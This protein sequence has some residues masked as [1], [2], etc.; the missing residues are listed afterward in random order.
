MKLSFNQLLPLKYIA[1]GCFFPFIS[2]C[3]GD[4][5]EI[6][7]FNS[8]PEVSSESSEVGAQNLSKRFQKLCEIALEKYP[9]L[10]SEKRISFLRY[11]TLVVDKRITQEYKFNIQVL[12]L[13]PDLIASNAT[14]HNLPSLDMYYSFILSEVLSEKLLSFNSFLN[15]EIQDENG[16]IFNNRAYTNYGRTEKYF[17]M[18]IFLG[19]LYKKDKE[20][21]RNDFVS[22]LKKLEYS[23]LPVVDNI[24][25]NTEYNPYN[26]SETSFQRSA[27]DA[28]LF[29][30]DL[31]HGKK[32]QN[33]FLE[34]SFSYQDYVCKKI[35]ESSPE[36]CKF[37]DLKRSLKF[38]FPLSK[39]PSS[40]FSFTDNLYKIFDQDQF[41]SSYIKGAKALK[42]LKNKHLNIGS[43]RSLLN[44]L[45]EKES[46][47][48]YDAFTPVKGSYVSL[49]STF[50]DRNYPNEYLEN[51]NNQ[52]E[53]K[54]SFAQVPITIDNQ[55]QS[56]KPSTYLFRVN[57]Q[58]QKII[59]DASDFEKEVKSPLIINSYLLVNNKEPNVL[60]AIEFYDIGDIQTLKTLNAVLEEDIFLPYGNI[61]DEFDYTFDMA[62]KEGIALLGTPSF[63]NAFWLAF[64]YPDALNY[65]NPT[66]VEIRREFIPALNRLIL[67]GTVSF[68]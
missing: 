3:N 8:F 1:I 58:E 66:K 17:L 13:N 9:D 55:D 40:T 12:Y 34:D 4:F 30:F 47:S 21:N 57:L 50:Q 67:R 31:V 24:F 27:I 15:S 68:N 28:I 14:K 2:S 43:T 60:K 10:M 7:S 63:I 22:F 25:K 20:F 32:S 64:D 41:W 62:S 26:K 29:G 54:V 59:C 33:S 37:N 39:T 11:F 52:E 19:E 18:G 46:A 44:R 56:K 53:N 42:K 51:W 5:N 35:K 38:E 61:Q 16:R 6:K 49:S 23:D 45:K 48:I 65:K 36:L